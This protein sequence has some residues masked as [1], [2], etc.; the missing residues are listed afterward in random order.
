M[1]I[2]LQVNVTD[3]RTGDYRGSIGYDGEK[4][5]AMPDVE[6][7]A[8]TP[9]IVPAGIRKDHPGLPERVGPEDDPVLFLKLLRHIYNNGYTEITEPFKP[10]GDHER[11]NQSPEKT[12]A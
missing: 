2:Q 10:T 12:P 8:K 9:V 5:V 3:G 1:T 11:V 4:I 7:Y 6:Y